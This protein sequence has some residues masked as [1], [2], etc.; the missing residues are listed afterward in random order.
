[1]SN[2][3]V[4]HEDVQN[5]LRISAGLNTTDGDERFKSIMHRL[6]E[7][8]CTLIDDYNITQEEFWQ[9]INYL[10]ELGG[11]QEA[12]LLAAGLGLEHYL[13]LRQDALDAAQQRETGTPRTIEGPLYVANAPLSESHARM[14]DGAD[15]GEVM[16]LHGQVKDTQGRPVENAIV[17]IW[18]A[19]TLGNYSF[20]DQSQSEY[21]LRRR[22]RTGADGRY[23]VRSIVPSGYGCP[24][25]GPT[26]K[27][28]D[29]LGRHGNRPAHIHFFVSAPG[30]KHLTSQI[31]LNGDQYLWD[32]FAFATRDGLIA[33]PVKVNESAKI[34]ERGLDGEHTEVHFDFTL[35]KAQAPDEEQRITRLRAQE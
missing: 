5:L 25:D 22:I 27:L 15:A 35:C 29:R 32:D 13:D 17:D 16:W 23:S 18:H 3:F 9:A 14:D 12:A 8:I 20:F 26:Q 11:R 28:L 31:N 2:S 34:A 6:L 1:M 21:N 24:P 33:D 4:K 19:N 7:N 10:H 30:H